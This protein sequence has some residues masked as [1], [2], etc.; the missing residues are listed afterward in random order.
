MKRKYSQ[1]FLVKHEIAKKIVDSMNL[2][3]GE[4]VIEV[5]PGK[6]ILTKELLSRNVRVIAIEIDRKLCQYL[7]ENVIDLDFYL[8]E[9][10]VLKINFSEILKKY[11]LKKIKIVSNL[12][13][14]ITTPFLEKI[15]E[16]R[17]I[18]EE[19]YLTL[20]KEVVDRITAKPGNKIY[21]SLTI[22]INYFMDVKPLFPI[23][24][25]FFR[26]I[27][28]VSSIFVKFVPREKPYPICKD[29]KIFF[30]VVRKVFSQRRKQIKN[31]LKEF[32]K[33]E[34]ISELSKFYDPEKRGEEFSPSDF[35]FISDFIYERK[36]E[37]G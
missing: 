4:W 12:P 1:V 28:K 30:Q 10:D 22:F 20:Q 18:F 8:E 32:L 3:K 23:P 9:G 27:P 31:V 14:H 5:G 6:G 16:E 11:K 24:R 19:I 33:E 2:K 29:E 7:R 25:F 15:I 36:N 35:A 34:E 13:Y 21:G 17:N 26:P 37:R